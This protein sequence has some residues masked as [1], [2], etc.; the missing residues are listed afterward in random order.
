MSRSTTDDDHVMSWPTLISSLSAVS[1]RLEATN[2]IFED[3]KLFC[4]SA[5]HVIAVSPTVL[6]WMFV[7]A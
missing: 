4:N 2:G 6:S 1:L 7:L 3:Y 5:G